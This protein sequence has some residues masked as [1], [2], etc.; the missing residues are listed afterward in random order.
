MPCD[1]ESLMLSMLGMYG[2]IYR[3][4]DGMGA[5]AYSVLKD[6]RDEIY[7]RT[8]TYEYKEGG[9]R[10]TTTRV[11]FGDMVDAMEFAV[12]LDEAGPDYAKLFRETPDF[13]PGTNAQR[14]Q[15][16]VKHRGH[17]ASDRADKGRGL[18]RSVSTLEPVRTSSLVR[19]PSMSL[20]SRRQTSSTAPVS[21][22]RSSEAEQDEEEKRSLSPMPT[23]N[24]AAPPKLKQPVSD[25]SSRSLAEISTWSTAPPPPLTLGNDDGV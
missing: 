3:D 24:T 17:A 6:I 11:L 16:H 25:G 18:Q 10:K 4:R 7:P 22:N 19:R 14:F 23:W 1:R 13:Q 8:F 21:S 2:E 20:D 12:R 5:E 15:S 9:E